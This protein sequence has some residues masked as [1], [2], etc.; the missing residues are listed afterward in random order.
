KRGD[1]AVGV[2]KQ[3][4]HHL[5]RSLNCQIG[6]FLAYGAGHDSSLVD[7]A[8]YMPHAWIDGAAR[9]TKAGVPESVQYQLRS[10]L[11]VELLRRTRAAGRL[12]GEWVTTWHGEGFEPDLRARLDAEGWRYLLPVAWDSPFFGSPDAAELRPASTLVTTEPGADLA[13][14]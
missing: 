3:Y 14:C 5:G 10:E 4:V 12:P 11:A 13:L 6:V 9:R 2:E 8:L 1:N 7:A